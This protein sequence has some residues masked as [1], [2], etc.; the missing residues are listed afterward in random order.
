M[1]DRGV[2]FEMQVA[3]LDGTG[4]LMCIH[5]GMM[6]MCSDGVFPRLDGYGTLA[7]L[8][9]YAKHHGRPCAINSSLSAGLYLA[10]R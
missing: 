6:W 7:R 9:L 3:V 2:F 5:D 10:C 1:C 8:A 4:G